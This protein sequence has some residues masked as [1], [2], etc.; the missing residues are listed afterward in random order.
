[1]KDNN[2]KDA[3]WFSHDSNAK[4]DP[5]CVLLIDQLGL[6][7]Y[8][9]YWVLVEILREQPDFSYPLSLVPAIAKRYGTSAPKVETVIR[10]FGLFEIREDKFFYSTSL[11]SRV[12]AF[13]EKQNR[14]S[15]AALRANVER[16]RKVRETKQLGQGEESERNPNGIRF[17]PKKRKEKKRKVI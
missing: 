7:G 1:M 5:K 14:R 11:I 12:L 16:W 13:K 2:N 6:E 8:G 15:A 4:D 3:Y 17:Y 9:I 10:N